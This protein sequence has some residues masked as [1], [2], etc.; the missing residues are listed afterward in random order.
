MSQDTKSKHAKTSNGEAK[1]KKASAKSMTKPKA[2]TKLGAGGVRVGDTPPL[3][4]LHQM[5]METSRALAKANNGNARQRAAR[6]HRT[7][8][9]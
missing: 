7:K 9:V 2:G 5:A 3:R 6:R 4:E 8:A 1:P